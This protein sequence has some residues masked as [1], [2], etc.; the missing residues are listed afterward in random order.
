MNIEEFK[1]ENFLI[2]TD[3]QKLDIKTIHSFLTNSYWSKGITIE[4]VERSIK[5]SLCFGVYVEG[6]QIGFARV[7]TDYT[8]FGYLADV[9]IV[10]EYRGKGLSKWLMECILNHP[11]V[12]DLR[13]WMLATKDAHDL[14]KKFGFK[15]LEE[16]TK[17]MA[18]KNSNR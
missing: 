6:K 9:F 18:K 14:Y 11:E 1:K 17:Y 8:L 4:K 7:T 13:S 16:P 15:P 12:Q 5:H 10:D 3:K 2:S